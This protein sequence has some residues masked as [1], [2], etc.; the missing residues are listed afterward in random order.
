MIG[1]FSKVANSPDLSTRH[2]QPDRWLA[3]K[4]TAERA[5]S[6]SLYLI[7]MDLLQKSYKKNTR[8]VRHAF[9]FSSSVLS[10]CESSYSSHF[11]HDLAT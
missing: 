1:R 6:L 11:W 5:A 10:F 7:L 8:D 9:P 2:C 4:P 3:A